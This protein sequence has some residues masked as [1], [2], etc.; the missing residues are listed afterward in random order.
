MQIFGIIQGGSDA[1]LRR[2]SATAI[3]ALPF[4]GFAIGGVAVGEATEDMRRTV[5][6]TAPLLPEDRPRYLMGVGTPADIAH[7]VSCGIDLFDCV[8]PTRDA[9][10]GRVYRWRD[11][12]A[13]P[14]GAWYETLNIGNAQ[15]QEE[16]QPIDPACA[17][18][19][20]RTVSLAYLRHLRTIDEPLGSRL[21]TL[22]NLAF[23]FDLMRMLRERIHG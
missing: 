8:L 7:A 11:R 19:T 10:H 15:Y 9:R 14:D 12:A 5:K 23:Y 17:C 18:P 1:E 22:H 2:A 13:F 4:D 16:D 6:A 3:T 21:A 20:C